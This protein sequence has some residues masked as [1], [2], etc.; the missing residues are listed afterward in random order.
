MHPNES[1]SV[2]GQLPCKTRS[3]DTVL[4]QLGLQ[5]GLDSGAEGAVASWWDYDGI[6]V[7]YFQF[8]DSEL[9]QLVLVPSVLDLSLE[10][11]LCLL[12]RT[13]LRKTK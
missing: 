12:Q 6:A 3:A 5:V 11:L 8:K 9:Q 13:H 10:P 4:S 2:D 1:S 7:S